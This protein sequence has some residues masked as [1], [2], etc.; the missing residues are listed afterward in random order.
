MEVNQNLKI[1]LKAYFLM[2]YAL[3]GTKSYHNHVMINLNQ[4]KLVGVCF[5]LFRK[6]GAG[7]FQD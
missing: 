6:V 5:K 3:L 2:N 4:E 7:D 1:F